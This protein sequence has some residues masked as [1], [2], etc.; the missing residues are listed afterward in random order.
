MK[1]LVTGA[2]KATAEQLDALRGL[3]HEIVFQQQE[4]DPLVCPYEEVEGVVCNGL[5]L[6]HSIEKFTSLRYI[7]LTS[8]GFDRVPM[9]YVKAHGIEIHNAR[10]VYSVPMAEHAIAGVLALYRRLHDFR[11]F[12]QQ[13]SWEKL[14]DLE[15]LNGKSVLILGCGSV[16]TECARRFAAFNC[17]VIGVDVVS[18]TPDRVFQ[19]F[20]LLNEL[21]ALLPQADVIVLTL[22][23]TDETR[24]LLDTRRLAL[25]KDRAVV[26][27]ISRGAVIDQAAL[28]KEI[29]SNRLRA[30][31]DV[32]DNE[33]LDEASQ[34]WTSPNAIVTPHVSFVGNH[35]PDRLAKV[36]L[37]NLNA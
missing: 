23:L 18:F 2:W 12:Q 9:D 26:V 11:A 24:K 33:P 16:G 7:Q 13:R 25:L 3:G 8:A 36:I 31:L 14:R 19:E 1:L 21:D 5:F 15:E 28:Q 17:R 22:P 20:H 32:F 27:S 37:E 10:G 30:V 29:A 34:L 4:K 35:N 6:S